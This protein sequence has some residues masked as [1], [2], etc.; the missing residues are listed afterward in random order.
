ME[1]ADALNCLAVD[2]IANGD[3]DNALSIYEHILQI[4]QERFGEIHPSI[5]GTY[6]NLGIV[7]AKNAA[8]KRHQQ[9]LGVNA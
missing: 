1:S 4:Q 5:A 2:H 6:H 3:F 7:H 9:L 8:T